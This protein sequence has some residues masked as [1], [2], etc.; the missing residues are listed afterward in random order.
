MGTVKL[1]VPAARLARVTVCGASADRRGEY[2][3]DDL[4][5]L[6][7]HHQSITAALPVRSSR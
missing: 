5:G 3:G 4:E 6:H 7:R 1:T 2:E